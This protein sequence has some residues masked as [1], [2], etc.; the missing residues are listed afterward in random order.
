MGKSNTE[1]VHGENQQ[2]RADGKVLKPLTGIMSTVVTLREGRSSVLVG[3]GGD[4]FRERLEKS[5]YIS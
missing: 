1:G 3:R 2:R 5:P 4:D